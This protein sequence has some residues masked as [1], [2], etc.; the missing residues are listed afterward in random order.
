MPEGPLEFAQ[1]TP[2]P[3]DGMRFDIYP[4]PH[5]RN[6][7]TMS[8]NALTGRYQVTSSDYAEVEGATVLRVWYEVAPHD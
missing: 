5:D 8:P 1:E 2:R 4:D 7:G 6:R 3:S